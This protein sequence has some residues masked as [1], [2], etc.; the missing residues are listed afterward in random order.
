MGKGWSYAM[1]MVMAAMLFSIPRGH[2]PANPVDD[3]IDDRITVQ[4]V[5]PPPP[6]TLREAVA[7]HPIPARHSSETECLARTVYFEAR[8]DALEGQMAVAR[9]VI[10]RTRS[11]LF[12]DSIC[13]VVRQPSQFSFVHHRVIPEV[14]RSSVAWRTSVAI[15][16]LAKKGWPSRARKAL[17]FHA[18]YVSPGWKRP[19]LG[20]IGA[21]LFYS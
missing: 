12:P 5:L 15:A 1:P 16:L 21:H 6:P 11:D 19:S 3:R 10:N 2:V 7:S 13:E 17:F 14:D 9:T 8:G 4:A 20:R 18:P